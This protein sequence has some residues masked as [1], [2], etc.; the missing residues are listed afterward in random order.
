MNH[1]ET[2]VNSAIRKHES[3]P[4]GKASFGW[5]CSQRLSTW[6][7]IQIPCIME[8][9]DRLPAGRHSRLYRA[10]SRVQLMTLGSQPNTSRALAQARNY[11]I[12][13]SGHSLGQKVP[14]TDPPE[15]GWRAHNCMTMPIEPDQ[16]APG[17]C[18]N[19]QIQHPEASRQDWWWSMKL[20]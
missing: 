15:P 14:A 11:N 7:A 3:I 9:H 12:V 16:I 19:P 17:C 4:F 18:T 10:E 6:Q 2:E 8:P 20:D 5:A 13:D 1:I